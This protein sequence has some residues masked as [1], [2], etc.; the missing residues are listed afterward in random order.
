MQNPSIQPKIL[1]LQQRALEEVIIYGD[2]WL[3]QIIQVWNIVFPVMQIVSIED[4]K[5]SQW[6]DI[7]QNLD[8]IISIQ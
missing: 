1:V 3:L 6:S 4:L 8:S 7:S 2:S 5:E